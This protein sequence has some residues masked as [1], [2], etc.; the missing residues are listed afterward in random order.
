MA[1]LRRA[2][3]IVLLLGAVAAVYGFFIE[4]SRLIVRRT[5]VAVSNWPAELS[6][7][8][9]VLIS[10]VH[11]GAPFIKETKLR[12]MVA[13]A[14]AEQA[15]L[16]LLLGDYTTQGV[17]GGTPMPPEDFAPILGE[18]RAVHGVYAILGNHDGW[19]D[20]ARI[21]SALELAGIRVL[22]N[23]SKQVAVRGRR[24]MLYGLADVLTDR[25]DVRPIAALAQPVIV[26]THSPDMFPMIPAGVALTVAG[27]THGGQIRLP[28]IGPLIVPSVFGRRYAAGHI[29]E[30]GRDLYVTTGVGTSII[31]VRIGVVPEITRLEIVRRP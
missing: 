11:A 31:P 9:V 6:G 17:I 22:R 28:F 3:L 5:T 8:R 14:N 4:P 10:D 24:L 27:H 25:P 19:F 26:M 2:V 12:R 23:E 20:A 21:E 18:L 1:G 15:D 16:I 30:R 7:L 13:M 29:V